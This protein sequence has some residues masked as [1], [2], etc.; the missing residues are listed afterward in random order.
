MLRGIV[1]SGTCSR[2][3]HAEC[4]IHQQIRR[5]LKQMENSHS[6]NLG[7]ALTALPRKII[8]VF[9]R[10]SNLDGNFHLAND[11]EA[12]Q[13]PNPKVPVRRPIP[14]V[15]QNTRPSRGLRGLASRIV[16]SSRRQAWQL[17]HDQTARIKQ[18]QHDQR[19][20]RK[21]L[22]EQHQL[23][24]QLIK[25]VGDLTP[26]TELSR[27]LTTLEGQV[28]AQAVTLKE[29][30][31]SVGATISAVQKRVDS[32]M[33]READAFRS[34]Q[35]L[36]WSSVFHDT[37]HGTAWFNNQA[38]APGRWAV[39]YPFLYLLYRLLNEMQ[40]KSILELGLG[41]STKVTSQYA[42]WKPGVRH[43][44]VEHDQNWCDFFRQ[45]F[46]LPSSSQ[47]AVLNLV[48]QEYKEDPAVLRYAGFAE[49]FGDDTYDL[50][51][52]DGPFGFQANVYA[53]IDV[54]D[55]IPQNLAR[56]FAIIVDDHDRSGE[57]HMANEIQS[58]LTES[59]IEYSQ[60][61]RK[62]TKETWLVTSSDLSFF[63]S[64]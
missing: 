28:V 26:R 34:S 48:T 54:L 38:L 33:D 47:V 41:E 2:P 11:S 29:E 23:L 14:S 27:S 55:L 42:A 5:K 20:M 21:M 16:P 12:S 24:G 9:R 51:C 31:G 15:P 17:A 30:I 39:G 32:L 4:A 7:R 52:V 18:L 3:I 56:S 61:V 60:S 57:R 59:G 10:S 40:P 37:I 36:I 25:S 62:G 6:C 49:A 44:V 1:F 43:Q 53:R 8:G 45:R 19:V 50:I 58:K 46:T 64:M 22:T 13:V 63:T 35:E